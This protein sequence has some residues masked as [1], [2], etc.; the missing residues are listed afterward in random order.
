MAIYK[1]DAA[2]VEKHITESMD[3]EKEISLS[4]YIALT[5]LDL[6]LITNQQAVVKLLVEHGAKLNVK[7]NPAILK[8]VRYGGEEI[9]RYLHQNGAKLNG[10]SRSS[11]MHTMKRI[12]VTLTNRPDIQTTSDKTQRI[13]INAPLSVFYM[14]KRHICVEVILR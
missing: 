5:P 4:K 3:L 12:T 2:A 7:D 9:I 11:P 14:R 1:G 6:A 13:Y 10:L 8:A